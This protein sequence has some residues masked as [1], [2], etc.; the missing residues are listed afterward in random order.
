[1]AGLNKYFASADYQRRA[2]NAVLSEIFE[3]DELDLYD[4][5]KPAFDQRSKEDVAFRHFEEGIYDKL[6]SRRWNVFRSSLAGA[7]HW[8]PRQVFDTIKREFAEFQWG[9]AINL[10]TFQK[11][12]AELHDRL[13]SCLRTMTGIKEKSGY[14]HM[15]V[16]KFLHFY[17]PE[18]FPIYDEAVIWC[19]V[20]HG[21]FR[22]DF[23]A[24]CGSGANDDTEAFLVY[25]IG[26]ASSL[27]L[28]MH[29]EFMQVFVDWLNDQ[30][31]TALS[32]RQFDAAT[33]YARAFEC[34][35]VGAAKE[36][37][38]HLFQRPGPCFKE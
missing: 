27:L 11:G 14:P 4:A 23:A 29:R 1:M 32:S 2:L 6:A 15:T 9:G 25:Y 38:P 8:L 5:S 12:P 13:K 37:C 18:L 31:Q 36:E 26:W 34:T 10:L 33:L 21:C 35:V 20:L 16:S 22:A 28:C 17:N 24:F 30:P 3:P 7:R 19:A